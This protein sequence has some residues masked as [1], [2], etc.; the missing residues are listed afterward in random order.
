MAVIPAS[1]TEY[2][3]VAITTSPAG[4]DLTATEPSWA[5]LPATD[6]GNP[7]AGDWLT[8]L[9]DGDTARILVGPDGATTLTRGDWH[10]WLR[11][12]PPNNE[13]V[14]RRAGLLSVT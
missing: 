7:E 1:S 5:F 10:V 2:V 12:D 13:L 6:R 3:S 14:V 9:W 4:L 8:G 11:V